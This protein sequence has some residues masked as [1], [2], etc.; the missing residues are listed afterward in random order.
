MRRR[1]ASP[2][3]ERYTSIFD[4]R[5]NDIGHGVSMGVVAARL[6]A[7]ARIGVW[8]HWGSWGSW[9]CWNLARECG[10]DE[11]LLVMNGW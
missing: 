6:H 9:A 8:D 10:V 5:A 1:A 7:R 3:V 2:L 11:L 4:T